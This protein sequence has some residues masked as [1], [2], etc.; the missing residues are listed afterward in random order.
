[1]EQ[2]VLTRQASKLIRFAI[3]QIKVLHNA[4][5]FAT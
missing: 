4:C 2:V 1:M 5:V 3:L